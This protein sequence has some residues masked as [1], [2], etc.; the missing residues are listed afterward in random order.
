MLLSEFAPPPARPTPRLALPV[1]L[2]FSA[3][4]LA[5]ALVGA[6]GLARVSAASEARHWVAHTHEV[7]DALAAVRSAADSGVSG[8]RDRALAGIAAG[9]APRRALAARALA[10]VDRVAAL[11]RDNPE[12]QARVPA[13]RLWTSTH[14]AHLRLAAAATDAGRDARPLITRRALVAHDS[15]GSVLGAMAGAERVLLAAREAHEERQAARLRAQVVAGVGGAFA[16]CLAMLVVLWRDAGRRQRAE[17]ERDALFVRMQEA[18]EELEAQNEELVQQS[19]E[20]VVQSEQLAVQSDEL[21]GARDYLEAVLTHM[22]DGVVAFDERGGVM[23][24]NPAAQRF[25]ALPHG[26]LPAESWPT[27]AEWRAADGRTA[28]G[29]GD[30]PVARVRAGRAVNAE[31]VLAPLGMR[32]GAR[33]HA[34]LAT[35]RPVRD[36]MGRYRGAILTLHDITERKAADRL[37]NELVSVVS[38]ELRTPLTSIRGSLGLLEGG[39]YGA[40]PDPVRRLVTIGRSNTDRLIRLVNDL[41]DLEKLEAGRL[42]LRDEPVDVSA[43]VA[44]SVE[45]VRSFAADQGV[46]LEVAGA[47]PG[48]FVV[49]GDADRLT[50]VVTNLLS[51]A[52]KFSPPQG[53]V[54]VA[55]APGGGAAVRLSVRDSG[56]GIAEHDLGRLFRRFHQLDGSDTRRYGGTGLGLAISKDLVEQHGGRVGVESRPGDGACFWVELPCAAPL[57]GAADAAADLAPAHAA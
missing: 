11:T 4:L 32:A 46:R 56:P 23:L 44:T 42:E 54:V 37:K 45:G 9:D 28:L 5:L 27:Y 20:L 21:Q 10:H 7:L 22:A 6:L 34:L 25:L 12:Q 33:A 40:L 15:V 55:L 30:A 50:Q 1:V 53:A 18:H 43:V 35:G 41:L 31:V 57:P 3:A 29:A 16:V 39:V 14:F 26:A 38:H 47:A 8:A 24:C 19:E 52:I 36:R 49:R 2:G 48:R 13:L 17:R 51:N